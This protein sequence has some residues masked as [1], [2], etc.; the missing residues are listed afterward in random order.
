MTLQPM[1]RWVYENFCAMGYHPC[2]NR[3]GPPGA[4]KRP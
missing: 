2:P 1:A 4:F 3:P